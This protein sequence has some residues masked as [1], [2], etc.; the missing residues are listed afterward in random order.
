MAELVAQAGQWVHDGLREY[1]LRLNSLPEDLG[2]PEYC[3]NMTRFGL[4]TLKGKC[5]QHIYS[6]GIASKMRMSMEGESDC[7]HLPPVMQEK[8]YRARLRAIKAM[9]I[10]TQ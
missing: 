6:I 9:E 7:D 4:M 1:R 5:T 10:V 3:R 2:D 8:V